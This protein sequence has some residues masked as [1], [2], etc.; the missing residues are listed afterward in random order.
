M[1]TNALEKFPEAVAAIAGNKLENTVTGTVAIP[2]VNPN[3][4]QALILHDYADYVTRYLKF[5]YG[6]IR[7][8]LIKIFVLKK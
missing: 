2:A 5:P 1:L 8:V 3:L 6:L 4:S 7:G